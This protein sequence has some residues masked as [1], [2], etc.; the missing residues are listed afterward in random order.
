MTWRVRAIFLGA[1][2]FAAAATCRSKPASVEDLY[3]TRMLG[4]SY[5]QR[6]QLPEAEAEFKKLT[7]LAPDDPLGYANLGLTYLQAARYAEAETQLRRARELDPASTEVGLALAKL[8]TLTGR[9]ADARAM[10]E[11]LRRDTTGNAHV[12]YALAE[13]EARQPDSASARR[14][15]DRLRDVLAVAPANLAVRLKLVDSFV[16]RGEVDSAVQQL[17]E[18]RRI[19]PEPPREARVYLDSTIQLLRT[20]QL[21][22][23]RTTFDRLVGLMEV[24]APYQAAMDDVKWTDGPI[25]GRAVL[26]YA[27]K[28]FISIRG[29]REKATVDLAKFVD[30]TE[31]AG[32]ASAESR[33][34]AGPTRASDAGPKALAT[35]DV[36]GDGTDDV[37]VSSWSSAQ[38]K[39]VPHLY[40]VQS[41]FVRDATDRS[42]ISLPQG[43]AFATFADYD[44]DG[45]LDLFVIGGEG[46]GHLFRNRG[47]GT[48]VDV[49]AK[50]G[51]GDAKGARKAVFGD[52]DHDG[53]LDLLLVGKGP[54]TLYRNNLDGTFTDATGS[55]GLA[56]TDDARD[57]VF[58]DFDGD[59]RIDIFIAN[60]H[61]SNLLFH[62]G[63]AQHF[64]DVTATSGLATRD[65]G[66]GASAV[67]DYNNDGFLDLFVANA[68]AFAPTLW[69]NKGNGTF[70]RDTRSNGALRVLENATGSAATFVD[71]DNDGWLD[72]VV[73]GGF[74]V[75]HRQ[76][77]PP[78]VDGTASVF[79][80]RND[81]TGKF[82]DRST[83][84]PAPSRASGASAIAVSDVDDDGDEDL[85]LMDGAGAPRLLRNDLGNSNLAVKVE[86]KGLRDGSGKNN[87]FGIGS[88]IELRTGDIYQ[89]RVATGRVTHFGLGSHLKADVLRIE[90]PNGVPQT[91][92]FP[93]SDQDVVE[94]EMLKGSCALAYTWDGKR[95]RFV[96]DAMWRSALGMPL[97]LMGGSSAFAPAGASQEYL[98]IPG[99]A[100]QPRDGR[101]VLQLTEELWETA[102]ADEVKLLS[103]DHPDSVEVF[104]DER[105]VPPGPVKLRVF[106]VARRELPITAIDERGND[107]LTALRESDDVYVSNFT[108]TKYQGVVE[109]H[110]L[111]MDLGDSAGRPDVYLFLR[112]WIYP[113]DASINVA[114]GQQSSIKVASPSLEVRDAK[115]RW[116]T[117]IANIGF[118]SGKDK[119]MVI[120][121]AGK[122]PT[123]NHH[124]R[125]RTNMQIYWDQ[126][127]V[128]R[129]IASSAAK[130]TTLAPMSA[131]LHFRGFSRMYR[132]GGRYGPYWFAYDQVAKESPWR[133]IEGAFT[134]FGDVLPLFRDADD[135]YVIM[136]PGDEATLEFDAS[137]AKALP[138]R[139]KRD[140]L[141]YTD[142]WIKDSDL[143]TAFGTTV[144][145]LP[146]HKIESYPFA[147]ADAYPTDAVH[148][149]Y[150]RHYNSR[151][152]GRR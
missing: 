55:L 65:D 73:G 135:M 144:G 109:P 150:Q 37:F 119:T 19:P 96:T 91:I 108:P 89:T 16:Q 1:G 26:T 107:V 126:A 47:D 83:L 6:N 145:P 61:G 5:L 68:S 74:V 29:V 78:H 33:A 49:T 128:A 90:W 40:R 95:F 56:G 22:Q 59:G 103:V 127:F 139:W 28:S 8:Y 62:N 125:I 104:V 88:R 24:T 112:G 7:T 3:T 111:V 25:P 124:V 94:R 64:I 151:Q 21:V 66:S 85:L 152:V 143:N 46:R 14:Y 45:W 141:L 69:L 121:L 41:G 97:G 18:V 51:I 118:P 136:G 58:A 32:L 31:D 39:S 30:A 138:L 99:D 60:E 116:R 63:G 72:L 92:Y 134:R 35:G 120:D 87:A 52:F 13:L 130:V 79:L 129:D 2:L 80:F 123:A 34:G 23:A 48:F 113:T 57:A 17:E 76:P 36:D 82:L 147:P 148:Q 15:Q 117:A 140:F 77:A 115:G 11:Q 100:L 81:G 102:Y 50:T 84:I 131:D 137:S 98:R 9:P 75:R 93:G 114:L 142:G 106:Q 12:L 4:L 27:P 44:N 20:G 101:Y 110:D 70:T 71:Y 149:N 86:L 10:L 132:K 122:F 133:P 146:F 105:F 42:G 53:D 54:R 43:A 38:G 67:G